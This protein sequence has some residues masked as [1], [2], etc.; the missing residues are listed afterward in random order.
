[1]AIHIRAGTRALALNRF[2]VPLPGRPERT[3]HVPR[4]PFRTLRTALWHLRNGG[5]A[6]LSTWRRRRSIAQGTAEPPAEV[7]TGSLSAEVL[8]EMFPAL[9]L[10]QR[11]PVFSELEVGVILDEFS[12]ESFGYEWSLRPLSF[13][14]WSDE[15]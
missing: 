7:A 15:L 1:L 4:T 8:A 13:T 14:D 9:P 2:T 10:P 6:Q 12:A 11:R 3:R 5:V